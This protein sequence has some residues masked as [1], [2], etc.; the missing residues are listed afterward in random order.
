[1]LTLP[2]LRRVEVHQRRRYLLFRTR[3]LSRDVPNDVANH[4]AGE[5][6]HRRVVD[7]RLVVDLNFAYH[8]SCTYDPRWSCPLAPEGNRIEAP[9]DAG[10][11]LQAG[12][13]Y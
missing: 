5:P 3:T 13:W 6:A 9:V 4:A 8:P 10:E 1:M 11:Q 2:A 7:G 12:G